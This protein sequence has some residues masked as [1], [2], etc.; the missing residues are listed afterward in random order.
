MSHTA[1]TRRLTELGER[2]TK[3]RQ[4]EEWE[5]QWPSERGEWSGAPLL[6]RRNGGFVSC[7]R[8]IDSE[9]ILVRGVQLA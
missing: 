4:G 1:I 6:R 3:G 9:R 7:M 2:N 8:R 5:Q